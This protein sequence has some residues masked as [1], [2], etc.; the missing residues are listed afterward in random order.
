MFGIGYTEFCVILLIII[1]FIGGNHLPQ[2][3]RSL[4]EAIKEFHALSNKKRKRK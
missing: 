3:G 1:I 4:G 2:I